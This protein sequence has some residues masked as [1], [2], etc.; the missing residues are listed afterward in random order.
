MLKHK[1]GKSLKTYDNRLFVR[2]DGLIINIGGFS[3]LDKKPI[4][5]SSWDGVT[6][7]NED[8][9]CVGGTKNHPHDIVRRATKKEAEQYEMAND[10][11]TMANKLLYKAKM[12]TFTSNE[13]FLKWDRAHTFKG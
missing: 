11:N 6:S 3:N 5:Y 4:I 2:R 10:I 7:W 1:D 9:T 12:M 8:G 13:A